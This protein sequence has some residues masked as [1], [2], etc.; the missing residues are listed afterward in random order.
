MLEV[1]G[2]QD[3]HDGPGGRNEDEEGDEPWHVGVGEPGVK[4]RGLEVEGGKMEGKV[5]R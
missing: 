2:E 3:A 5:G 1:L 4:T